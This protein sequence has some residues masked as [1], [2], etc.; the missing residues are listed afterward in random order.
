MLNAWSGGSATTSVTEDPR[1]LRS[2]KEWMRMMTRKRSDEA[3]LR[4]VEGDAVVRVMN[5]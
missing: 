2:G 4:N 5:R 1:S 3:S